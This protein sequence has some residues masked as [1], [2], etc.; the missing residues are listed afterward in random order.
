MEEKEKR[1]F[2]NL[3]AEVFKALD[4]QMRRDILRYVGEGRNPTFTDI[5]N[6]IRISDSPT[7]AYHLKT[8]APFIEQRK[9]TY[10]LT[11]MGK[12]AFNLLLKAGTYSKIA[13]FQKKQWEAMLGNAVLWCGAIVAAAYLEASTILFTAILPSMAA[14]SISITYQLFK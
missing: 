10:H 14:V 11:P 4:H 9:G 8:L 2:G 13:L 6:A 5:L 7:L 3:E 12:D 1:E